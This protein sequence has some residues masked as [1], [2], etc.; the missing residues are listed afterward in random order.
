[1]EKKEKLNIS[2]KCS[3][4]TIDEFIDCM[5]NGNLQRL[6]R[7]GNP[8]E[9]ELNAAWEQIYTEYCQLS[10]NRQH[11]YYFGLHKTVYTMKLKLQIVQL[12]LLDGHNNADNEIM[13]SQLHSFGYKGDIKSIIARLKFET[14]ELQGKENELKKITDKQT[15]TIKESDFD[16]WIVSVGKYLG[17]QIKR[18]EMILSEFLSANKAMVKELEARNKKR[19][20]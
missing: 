6:V 13:L 16:D 11:T 17:Y 12:L 15:G 2:S 19:K 8:A 1:M 14:V 4:I 7:S 10:G 5:L 20:Y 18:K 3:E 9:T